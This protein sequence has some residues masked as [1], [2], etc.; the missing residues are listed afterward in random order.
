MTID[1]AIEEIK[2]YFNLDLM[3]HSRDKLTRILDATAKEVVKEKVIVKKMYFNYVEDETAIYNITE[4]A[5]RISLLYNTDLKSMQGKGRNRNVVS[6]RAHLCRYMKL[7]SKI[8]SVAL[9]QYLN[10]HHSSIL[11]LLY[12]NKIPCAI[13]PL[14]KKFVQW[15]S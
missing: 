4:E 12:D 13:A 6:A 15:Q 11:H 3:P 9:G 8:T 7:N 10:R 1:Q 5:N 14:Y 2:H